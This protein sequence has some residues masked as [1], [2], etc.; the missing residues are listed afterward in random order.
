MLNLK[1]SIEKPIGAIGRENVPVADF[2]KFQD[3]RTSKVLLQTPDTYRLFGSFEK[4]VTGT[5]SRPVAHLSDSQT[6]VVEHK[7]YFN[8]AT[9]SFTIND[10]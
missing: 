10:H 8:V 6:I 5:F 2:S 7:Q 1:P 3:E 9:Q 4:S